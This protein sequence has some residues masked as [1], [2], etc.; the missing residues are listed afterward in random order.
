MSHLFSSDQVLDPKTG[1]KVT[2][3]LCKNMMDCYLNMISYSSSGS[4]DNVIPKVS[5]TNTSLYIKLFVYNMLFHIVVVLILGNMFFGVVMDT[6][7]SLRQKTDKVN[8]DKNNVCFVCQEDKDGF[9]I[10][11]KDPKKTFNKHKK[12]DHYIWNYVYFIAYLHFKDSNDLNYQEYY[13]FNCLKNKDLSWIPIVKKDVDDEI[14]KLSKDFKK[15]SIASIPKLRADISRMIRGTVRQDDMK[16]ESKK[17]II[18]LETEEC[19]HHS[20]EGEIKPDNK[21]IEEDVYDNNQPGEEQI[22]EHNDNEVNNFRGNEY[23]D[24]ALKDME[25]RIDNKLAKMTNMISELLKK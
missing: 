23:Y 19:H 3:N 20:K 8:H 9:L 7:N 13:V 22:E 2:E 21:E 10:N 17:K 5:S 18:K 24:K 12:E 6:F 16:E 11:N 15:L 25:A 4:M 1:E 14:L